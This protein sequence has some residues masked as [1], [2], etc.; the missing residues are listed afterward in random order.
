MPYDVVRETNDLIT[1][2]LGHL[3]KAFGLSLV[4]KSIRWKVDA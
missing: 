2:T 4:F 1:G 3:G